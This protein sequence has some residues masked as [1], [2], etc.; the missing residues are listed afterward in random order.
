M[1]VSFLLAPHCSKTASESF[2]LRPSEPV[3]IPDTKLGIYPQ[4]LQNYYEIKVKTKNRRECKM[5]VLDSHQR[6]PEQLDD[7]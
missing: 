2:S 4:K 3:I 7:G 5:S 1:T 6:G